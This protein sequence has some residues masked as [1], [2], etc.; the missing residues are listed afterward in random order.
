MTSPG[1]DVVIIGGGVIGTSCAYALT[2]QDVDRVLLIDKEQLAFGSSGSSLAVIETQYLDANMVALTTYG[3]RLCSRLEAD[4]GLPFAHDGYLRL[5]KREGDVD[6][7][8]ESIHI[9]AELGISGSRVLTPKEVL[10]VMPGLFI[11]DIVGALWGP[12]DG[13]IDAPT[14]CNILM[15]IAKGRGATYRRATVVGIEVTAGA[16]SGVELATGEVLKC[17]AVINA[18]GAWAPRVGRMVGL[19]VPVDGYRRQVLV[20][21]PPEPFS[22]GLPFVI[23]YV[24]GDENPGLY[25]RGDGPHRLLVGMH[26]EGYFPDESCENPDQFS[27]TIDFDYQAELWEKL[28]RRLPWSADLRAKGGWAGLY[29]LTPDT[30]FIVGESAVKGFFNAAGGGGVGVQCSAGIGAMVTEL[31]LEGKTTIVPHP[32]EYDLKRFENSGGR[33]QA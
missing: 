24:P 8:H 29:P 17:S 7:Y 10:D 14:Y 22:R 18:A 27:H 28:V 15:E 4:H 31:L 3:H 32:D 21:E 25:F 19:Q 26:E 9:Q 6:R 11:E 33:S 5:A 20:L 12:N 13:Y 16:V 2:N 23:D 1:A 30:K